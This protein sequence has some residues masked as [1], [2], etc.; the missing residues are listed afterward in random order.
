MWP[1]TLHAPH[2]CGIR[3]ATPQAHAIVRARNWLR[4]ARGATLTADVRAGARRA[5]GFTLIEL[6]VVL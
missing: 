6:M 1:R 4:Q 5:R 3:H 2:K